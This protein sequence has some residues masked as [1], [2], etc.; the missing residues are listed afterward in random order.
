MVDWVEAL[1]DAGLEIPKHSDEFSVSCPFHEDKVSSCSINIDKGVWICFA[2]CGQGSLYSFLMKYL[3]ISYDEVQQRIL[4]TEASF[5]LDMFD[6]FIP[7]ED[8]MVEVDFPFT[9]GYVPEW[10]FDRGFDKSTLRKWDCGLGPY[11]SLVIPIKDLSSTL[12]GWVTRRQNITPKYL[13][14]KGLKKSRLLFGQ[15][16]LKAPTSFVCITEGSLDTM[17]LDQHGFSSVALLG[18]SISQVQQELTLQIPTEELVLCLD[19][20]EA[21]RIGLQ[22]AMTC[23][24]K[25]FMVSYVKL[26]KEYKD[27]QDI[28]DEKILE[29]IIEQRTFL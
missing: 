27:V 17:W 7:D 2:G 10:I 18:A 11:D 6:E 8:A 15:Q 22:K 25:N 9:R 23:L 13:Y 3:H 5:N 20:D 21:G 26:P 4:N 19:N 12:V 1:L 28:R 14:S 24:S 29:C 16:F